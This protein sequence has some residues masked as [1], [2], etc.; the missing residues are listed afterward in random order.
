M[1]QPQPLA[2]AQLDAVSLGRGSDQ[3]S[4]QAAAGAAAAAAAA[5][6]APA[7]L[8]EALEAATRLQLPADFSGAVPAATCL[9][10]LKRCE[11]LLAK[12]PTVVHVS[13]CGC[14]QREGSNL[15]HCCAAG[16]SCRHPPT[17]PA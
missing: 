13:F 4:S 7:K 1:A 16:L 8:G 6:A 10:L 9:T 5:I 15:V 17:R 3:N 11:R 12:E 2:A 14:R